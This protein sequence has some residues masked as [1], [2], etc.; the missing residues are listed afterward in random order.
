MHFKG[1]FND[2]VDEVTEKRE[3]VRPFLASCTSNIVQS[4]E[5]GGR[6]RSTDSQTVTV[7][8]ESFSKLSSPRT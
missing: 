2:A 6:A 7:F 5:S 3:F 1:K 8:G 4:T